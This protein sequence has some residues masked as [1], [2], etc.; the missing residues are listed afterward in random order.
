MIASASVTGNEAL[1]PEIVHCFREGSPPAFVDGPVAP[2]RLAQEALML[3]SCGA[4]IVGPYYVATGGTIRA[5][6]EGAGAAFV[7]VHLLA[8]ATL[9]L[10]EERCVGPADLGCEGQGP[11]PF[12]VQVSAGG[13]AFTGRLDVTYAAPD[14]DFAP[15]L[16]GIFPLA[17]A[18]VAAQWQRVELGPLPTFDTSGPALAAHLAVGADATWGEGEGTADPGPEEIYTLRVPSG[19]TFRLAGMHIRTRELDH[20]V[21]ITMWWSPR[22]SETFGADRPVSL[23]GVWSHYAMCVAIDDLERDPDPSG[24]FADSAPTLAEALRAVLH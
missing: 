12:Y 2:Q 13:R 7:T 3:E 11:S 9:P 1:S 5:T 16:D 21:N 17:S 23:T 18:T 19:G 6:V 8:G 14:V 4:H 10:A 20:W 24:G 22:P 15:C